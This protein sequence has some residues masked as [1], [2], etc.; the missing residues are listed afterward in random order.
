MFANVFRYDN[1]V[2]QFVGKFFDLMV[3]NILWVICSLPIVTIGAST[4]AVYYVTLKLVRNEEGAIIGSFFKSFKENWKQATV[5]WL[6][7]LIFGLLLGY[8]VYFFFVWKEGAANIR[9]L[10]QALFV[11]FF[12]MY[13]GTMTFVFPLQAK[14]YNP[15]KT[16]IKNAFWMSIRHIGSTFC[17]LVLDFVIVLTPF[18]LLP[19]LQPILILFGLPLVTFIN[20]YFF[21]KIFDKYIPK[22]EE[23]T[24]A[25]GE[26]I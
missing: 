15:I 1:P 17:M 9:S 24:D 11:G 19:P 25:F 23:E 10:I 3:L 20:S 16:T 4:T 18:L 2:W 12:L 13:L 7:L 6:V 5:I 21:V 26:A 22:K 14:F 8:D